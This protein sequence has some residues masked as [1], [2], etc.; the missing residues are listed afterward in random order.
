MVA[1]NKEY[2]KKY[3]NEYNKNAE[4]VYCKHCDKSY[5]KYH[6]NRH[7]QTNRH[8]K[9]RDNENNINVIQADYDTLKK[10]HDKLKLKLKAKKVN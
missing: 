1:N 9:N 2:Q 5:K 10:E 8:I 7:E 3:M 4:M 6:I